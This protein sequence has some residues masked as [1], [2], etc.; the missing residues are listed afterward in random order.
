MKIYIKYANASLEKI[1]FIIFLDIYFI[2]IL[3]KMFKV[4]LCKTNIENF[5]K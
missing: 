4:K 5:F 3:K 1:Y 2:Y